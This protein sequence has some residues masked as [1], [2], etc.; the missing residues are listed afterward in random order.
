MLN[1]A[2]LSSPTVDSLAH[3]HGLAHAFPQASDLCDRLLEGISKSA[4]Y[5]PQ[6]HYFGQTGFSSLFISTHVIDIC[7]FVYIK[8]LEA[9]LTVP[10]YRISHRGLTL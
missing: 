1:A 3:P 6:I 7:P 9:D 5:H 8:N 10:P 2:M 4:C